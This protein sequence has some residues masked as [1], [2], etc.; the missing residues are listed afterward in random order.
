MCPHYSRLYEVIKA[1]I[2]Y[3]HDPIHWN[4]I[5]NDSIN[6]DEHHVILVDGFVVAYTLDYKF[7]DSK[8]RIGSLPL[9]HLTIL[10]PEFTTEEDIKD[11]ILLNLQL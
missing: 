10:T 9:R 5:S 6:I 2:Q 11:L 1:I 8:R 4:D 3:S 7:D